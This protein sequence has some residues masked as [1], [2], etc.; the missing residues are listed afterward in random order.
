MFLSILIFFLA[1]K[2]LWIGTCRFGSCVNFS[3][4]KKKIAILLIL[5]Y[6]FIYYISGEIVSRASRDRRTTAVNAPS[7]AEGYHL[8]WMFTVRFRYCCFFLLILM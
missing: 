3:H 1:S 8:D 4:Y 6:L 5:V 7:D 2:V